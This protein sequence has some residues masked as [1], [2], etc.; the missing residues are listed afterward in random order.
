MAQMVNIYHCS[1]RRARL[2]QFVQSISYESQS[3]LARQI[4]GEMAG[5]GVA[6]I[7]STEEGLGLCRNVVSDIS[8]G[9]PNFGRQF[10]TAIDD[11]DDIFEVVAG[12]VVV[13]SSS[14]EGL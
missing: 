13:T 12:A 3:A 6:E 1:S 7:P 14:V 11:R 2:R 8:I 9:G 10:G 4:R 5:E